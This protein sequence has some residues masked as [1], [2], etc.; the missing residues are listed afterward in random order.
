MIDSEID[1]LKGFMPQ[2]E[3]IALTKW[4]E[5]ALDAEYGEFGLY[6]LFS[7]KYPFCPRS[8]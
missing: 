3:G 8:P 4:S 5:A 7:S 6:E 2:H 1:K